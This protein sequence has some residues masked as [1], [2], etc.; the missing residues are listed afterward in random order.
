[1]SSEYAIKVENLTKI[2]PAYDKP[3]DRLKQ[4][5]FPRIQKKCFGKARSY[6]KGF[7]ALENVTFDV[8]RGETVGIIGSNGSGK[9]TL[10][11]IL[12][13]TLSASSGKVDVDGKV[14][15]LLEL[16]SG[17]NPEF[18][19]RENIY[20]NATILGLT[21]EQLEERFGKIVEFSGIA[22]FLDQPVK[23]YSSGMA[24][25]LA[26]SV[27]AHVDADILIID[28]ALSVG[29]AAFTQ[30]C[31]RFL[32]KFMETNT[33]IF[34]SHDLA[35][36]KNLCDRAIWINRGIKMQDGLAEE[37]CNAYLKF[38]QTKDT[39]YEISETGKGSKIIKPEVHPE[40]V[41]LGASSISFSSQLDES[42]GW[43]TGKADILD[44]TILNLDKE[45]LVFS[46]G[47][48][49]KLEITAKTNSDMTQPILGFIVK[50]RLGQEL[51]GENTVS[52]TS[53]NAIH[54]SEGEKF[55]AEFDFKLPNLQNGIYT[56]MVVLSE[57]TTEEHEHHHYLHEACFI[58]VYS[59]N[60][61]LGIMTIPFSRVYLEV[62]HGK[63]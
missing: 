38:I 29:D 34:V 7:S 46:G 47:D 43:R 41:D 32:R 26:F 50:D 56:V 18:S 10:L 12:C 25:R 30:K 54:L 2:Y 24:V 4:F 44:V 22:D 19:G 8:K 37:V 49:V 14:A 17:F 16:G 57:G 62:I 5:L 58:E 15:A 55:R 42:S 63:T 61:R 6:Y 3:S 1:M 52:F 20:L 23:T 35:S 31:M 9:S 53:G 51:F 48:K 59:S 28:E 33:L 36:V 60:V 27:I 13:N 40:E 11:Q 21:K 39:T 45:G